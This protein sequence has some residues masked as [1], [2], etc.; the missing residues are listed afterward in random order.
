MH[1]F[2]PRLHSTPCLA[3]RK[4]VH[5]FRPTRKAARKSRARKT[6]SSTCSSLHAAG[7]SQ[8]RRYLGVDHCGSAATCCYVLLRVLALRAECAGR[9]TSWSFQIE[10]WFC[11]VGRQAFLVLAGFS[12]LPMLADSRAPHR[13]AFIK[14][15][16]RF[17]SGDREQ[18][19]L[20]GRHAL[21]D[22][23]D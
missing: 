6:G 9:C 15:I 16:R 23:L 13:S 4:P 20:T 18:S 3:R 14:K 17:S 11:R 22:D 12:F 21:T 10:I 8:P 5:H 7:G 1:V 2:H 19:V